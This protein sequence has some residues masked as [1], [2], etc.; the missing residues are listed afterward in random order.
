MVSDC[1]QSILF[2]YY[3]WKWFQQQICFD[4]WLQ[5]S[6]S[7]VNHL[8]VH[9]ECY[10]SIYIYIPEV[11]DVN[12]WMMLYGGP[13]P[14]RQHARSNWPAIMNLD[15]G[16]LAR[17]VMEEKT[18]FKTSSILKFDHAACTNTCM[19]GC[20]FSVSGPLHMMSQSLHKVRK[21]KL[22]QETRTSRRPSAQPVSRVYRFVCT[23]FSMI[24]IVDIVV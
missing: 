12:W 18:Q 4:P 2:E 13:T 9:H 15:A 19:F 21:E 16:K 24:L 8:H 17:K 20:M 23:W 1:R 7:S 10:E 11:H 6:C 3:R 14:K 5:W 22:G